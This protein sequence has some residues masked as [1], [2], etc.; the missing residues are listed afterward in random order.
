MCGDGTVEEGEECD[1]GGRDPDDGCDPSCLVECEGGSLAAKD[2][3]TFHCYIGV[4]TQ[5][6][7]AN[8]RV[9]CLALGPGVDLVAPSTLEE[10]DFLLAQVPLMIS[11]WTGG[12]DQT[13]E[14][15]YDW[16]NGETWSYEPW[17]AN[18][19]DRDGDCITGSPD[20]IEDRPC[21]EAHFYVCERTP[22]GT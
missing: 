6:S 8:A 17:I 12:N 1:D 11:A 19:P 5:R 9:D 15:D 13:T 10:S 20:G 2:P 14:G 4:A 18:Q 3:A 22:A 7:W 16:S 21:D